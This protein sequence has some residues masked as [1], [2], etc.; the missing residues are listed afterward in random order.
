MIYGD[1]KAFG[2]GADGIMTGKLFRNQAEPARYRSKTSRFSWYR[3]QN[4]AVS[5]KEPSDFAYGSGAY[6]LLPA[7]SSQFVSLYFSRRSFG[8]NPILN[9]LARTVWGCSPSF[10]AAPRGPLTLP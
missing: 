1:S 4:P 7:L 5:G 8:F 6:L 2:P 9:S 10:P 3:N